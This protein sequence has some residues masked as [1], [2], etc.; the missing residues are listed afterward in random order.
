MR[1][2]N[3]LANGTDCRRDGFPGDAFIQ[4]RLS[5]IGERPRIWRA[6]VAI[7]PGKKNGGESLNAE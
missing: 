3:S 2:G 5:S 6:D 4:R 1:R 7:C